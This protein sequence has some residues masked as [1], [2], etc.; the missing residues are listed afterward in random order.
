LANYSGLLQKDDNPY[1]LS[2][3]DYADGAKRMFAGGVLSTD[4]LLNQTFYV[5]GLNQKDFTKEKKSAYDSIYIGGGLRGVLFSRLGYY[6]E[7]IYEMGKS[8]G[9]DGLTQPEKKDIQAMAVDAGLDLSFGFATKPVILLQYT[10]GSGDGD[11]TKNVNEKGNDTHFISLG[12]FNG[13]L[14]LNPTLGNLHVL[15]GGLSFEP[16]DWTG[17]NTLRR[18][19]LVAKY[20]YYMKDK[21]EGAINSGEATQPERFVGQGGDASLRWKLFW[22]MSLFASYGIFLPG[23]AYDD[24]ESQR[25][26]LLFGLNLSF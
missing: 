25:H 13:G 21:P 2:S 12:T 24:N 17:F 14:G 10:F 1:R 22:D 26:F 15:R 23:K 3:A 9:D 20:S 16:L 18:I 5:Y 7:F 11:R 6:G 4:V 8:Y 19:T